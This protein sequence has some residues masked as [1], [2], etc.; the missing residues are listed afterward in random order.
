MAGNL[1]FAVYFISSFLHALYLPQVNSAY[2]LSEATFGP[3]LSSKPP[4]PL[5]LKGRAMSLLRVFMTLV[6]TRDRR[7]T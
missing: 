4:S 6:A 7:M 3:E 1:L 2:V 5:S